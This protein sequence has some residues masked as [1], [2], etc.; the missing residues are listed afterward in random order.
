[1]DAL[2]TAIVSLSLIFAA[3]TLGSAFV[4]FFRK[5]FGV[6]TNNAILGFAGGIMIAASIFGLIN[7]S[8]EQ[9][10]ELYKNIAFLPP[11]GGFLLGCIA[12]WLLDIIVPHLH[13]NT[14]VEEG[15]KANIS[16]NLKFF[17]AVT[18][19]NIPE[20]L[21]VGF[22]A[23]IALAA[24]DPV[25]RAAACTSALALAIGIAIQNVPEGAAISVPMFGRGEKKG[26]SFLFGVAS[27]VVEPIF[28]VLGIFLAQ[29][30]IL[31]PWLLSFAA[32]AMFYVTLDEILPES[33]KGNFAHYGLWSFLIGFLIMMALEVIPIPIGG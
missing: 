23:G 31:T 1:M 11:L 26:R 21:A 25:V 16:H 5:Q 2:T 29:L 27:G 33:R 30:S 17:L 10:N 7:P 32:G 15:R 18:I 4:F 9:S 22:A 24:E 8:I 14:G 20:G 6:K 3:T 19:H 12:L 28:G 13:A